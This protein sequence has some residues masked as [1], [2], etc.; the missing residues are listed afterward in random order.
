MSDTPNVDNIDNRI[1]LP[2]PDSRIVV[3]QNKKRQD[4]LEPAEEGELHGLFAH[5][6]NPTGQGL[7]KNEYLASLGL[8]EMSDDDREKLRLIRVEIYKR[9]QNRDDLLEKTPSNRKPRST[10][11]PTDSKAELYQLDIM[12][13]K[14]KI[15]GLS[16]TFRGGLPKKLLTA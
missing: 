1:S 8:A 15:A 16:E 4:G 11:K 6:D 13:T 14:A 10:E 12:H 7:L 5:P 9:N 3:L 2:K